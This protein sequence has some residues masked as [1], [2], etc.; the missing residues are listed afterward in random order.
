MKN[1][2]AFPLFNG[3]VCAIFGALTGY[4][5]SRLW[6]GVILGGLS[7][8]VL[9]L[10]VEVTTARL[11]SGHWLYRR[12]A[13]LLALIEIPIAIFVVA[14]YAYVLVNAQPVPHQI[15]CVTPLDYGAERY[16][17]IQVQT[18]DGIVLSGWF[19]P[20]RQTP[21][22]VIVV[23][24]GF[25]GDRRG[26]EWHA[27]QLIQAGYGV[28]LYD[29]RALGKSTGDSVSF[30]WEGPDLLAVLDD[31]STRPE[32]D[33][34]RI[35]VVGLSGGGHVAL[36]A[37]YL[38]P[39]RIPALWLDGIQAQRMEDFPEPDGMG[40]SF[41]TLMNAL[42]L[43]MAEF[44]T[45]R[46]SPPA[47]AQILPALQKP[48]IMLVAGGRDDFEKRVNHKYAELSGPNVQFWFIEDAFHTAGPRLI[49][50]EYSQKMLDF[51]AQALEQ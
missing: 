38:Q 29:Q 22:A 48:Q 27:R 37:A 12:R 1:K 19:V 34:Q 7:G 5:I 26:A 16:E 6:W 35:G 30:S 47:F 36:N 13:L 2:L 10:L 28:L 9:G 31:L 32:V 43:K 23:L 39:E 14:P 40:E 44:H 11:G 42:I 45:G 46:P 24:H 41:A 15:C 17:D 51:F 20:P 33:G 25:R 21:G 8:F 50:D 4:Y 49:P 3:L 18:E